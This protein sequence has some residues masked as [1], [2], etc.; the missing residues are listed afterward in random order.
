MFEKI[1]TF[2]GVFACRFGI[3][4]CCSQE[5][6]VRFGY[7]VAVTLKGQGVPCHDERFSQVAPYLK[8]FQLAQSTEGFNIALATLTDEEFEAFRKKADSLFYVE[9]QG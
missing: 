7:W 5:F 3:G 2:V 6:Y 8:D 9:V 1:K 4:P